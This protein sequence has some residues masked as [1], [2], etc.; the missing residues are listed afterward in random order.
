[1]K[2]IIRTLCIKTLVASCV[3]LFANAQA[4]TSIYP[5]RIMIADG[6]KTGSVTLTNSSSSAKIYD[7]Q[8]S[9][10]RQDAYGNHQVMVKAGESLED[11]PFFKYLRYSPRKTILQSRKS[12]VFRFLFRPPKDF[13]DGE[14]RVYVNFVPR[15]SSVKFSKDDNKDNAGLGVEML[16]AVS[17]PL[18]IRYGDV[19]GGAKIS[20]VSYNEDKKLVSFVLNREG[21]GSAIGKIE[22][23]AKTNKGRKLIGIRNGCAIYSEIERRM[24]FISVMESDKFTTFDPSTI[25]VE[26]TRDDDTSNKVRVFDKVHIS[27]APKYGTE[28]YYER[29]MQQ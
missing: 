6:K 2:K 15:P 28:W 29:Q 22:V 11:F 27:D 12:Q 10:M 20:D 7:L 4:Y 23:Y 24:I 8:F 17:I 5:T 14:Y 9:V 1:M 21:N 19:T 25:E 26:Y 18:I 13:A 16:I 3:F